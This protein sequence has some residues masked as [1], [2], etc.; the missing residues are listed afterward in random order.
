MSTISR[1][2]FTPTTKQLQI[3]SLVIIWLGF[4]LRLHNLAG[5][6]FWIDEILTV[7]KVRGG[8]SEFL[9]IR[10][11]PPL[12]YALT[13]LTLRTLG[14]TEFAARLPALAAGT[15]ALPLTVLLGKVLRWPVAGLWAALLLAFSPVHVAYAQEARHYALLLAISLAA[16][17]LVFQALKLSRWS[18]WVAFALMTVLN[19]YNHYGAFVVL[20]SQMLLISGWLLLRWRRRG[21]GRAWQIW[22]YPIVAG[23]LVVLLYLPWISRLQAVVDFNLGQDA[24]TPTSG[25]A[26]LSEWA[27]LL[28][29][30]FGLD[31]NWLPHALGMDR[32]WLPYVIL[33]L[34]LIG[35]F[36]LVSRR[37]WLNLALIVSALVVPLLLIQFLQVSRGVYARYVLY[38]LPFYLFTASVTVTALLERLFGYHYGRRAYLS[39]SALSVALVILI[40]WP[41]VEAEYERVQEDWRGIL[42]Y[43]DGAAEDGAVLVGASMNY[44]NQFNLVSASLPYYLEKDDSDYEF[45]AANTFELDQAISLDGRQAPVWLIVSDWYLDLDNSN[46]EIT[47][48]KSALFVGYDATQ[49]GTSLERAV[50][51]YQELVAEV[52]DPQQ[53]CL[54]HEDLATIL[55]AGGKS[56][57]ALEALD[58]LRSNCPGFEDR[59]RFAAATQAALTHQLGELVADGRESEAE[60]IA[61]RLLQYDR[62]DSSALD[63]LTEVD[64]L[65]LQAAGRTVVDDKNTPESVKVVKFDMPNQGDAEDVLFVHPPASVKYRLQLPESPVELYTRLAMA[66]E[67]WA[68][69]GDGA[70]FVVLVQ[71]VDG[72]EKELLRHHIDSE[73]QR[74]GWH[75]VVIS[76]SDYAGQDVILTLATEAGPAGDT[77]GDWAGWEMPRIL[78]MPS[79]R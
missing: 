22:R 42:D 61:I 34:V 2:Q 49:S 77:T 28:F 17:I 58:S 26:P 45:L 23:L 63:V 36:V 11:H 5:D 41:G 76:L 21:L 72:D 32:N 3:A 62:N 33:F 4:W 64:L 24:A 16:Y 13:S 9:N 8:P 68:W 43:L 52:D 53:S 35:L 71:T 74:D 19:L 39:A 27:R 59:P 46:L 15:L 50:A 1:N 67:S 60:V 14:E 66:P 70:T 31:R 48:F 20:A 10:D 18:L 78:R 55:A 54:F 56:G 75:E 47:P 79:P 73:A 40:A 25:I 29:Y 30:A 7:L 44:R 69:G 65:E 57:P 37:E 12:M 38:M 6:S 51:L